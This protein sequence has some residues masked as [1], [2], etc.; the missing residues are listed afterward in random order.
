MQGIQAQ[1]KQY[2]RDAISRI[3]TVRNLQNKLILSTMILQDGKKRREEGLSI[4]YNIE[5]KITDD[6]PTTLELYFKVTGF[7]AMDEKEISH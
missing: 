4:E 5:G 6:L 7:R 2:H 3:Q 1:D